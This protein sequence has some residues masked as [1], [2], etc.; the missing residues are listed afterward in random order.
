MSDLYTQ[1]VNSP[2]GR[3][4]AGRVGLPQPAKLERQETGAAEI[5]GAVLSGGAPG[6]RLS[7][8]VARLLGDLG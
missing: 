3:M 6:G 7:K 5:T 2:P 4:I 8:P 1:V